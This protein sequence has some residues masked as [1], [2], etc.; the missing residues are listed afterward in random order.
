MRHERICELMAALISGRVRV[1]GRAQQG[2][3]HHRVMNVIAV[4][5]VIEQSDAVDAIAEVSPPLGAHLEH[6]ARLRRIHVRRP[7]DVPEL[8]L[9]G[10]LV[11][12]DRDWKCHLQDLV[13]LPPVDL[14]LEV[15]DA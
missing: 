14:G 11:G 2:Q 7:F 8:N 1:G 6:G 9:V 13:T 5:A 10:R 3:S 12:G 15:Q 4:L